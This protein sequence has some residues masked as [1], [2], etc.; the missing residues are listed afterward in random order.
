MAS[1]LLVDDDDAGLELRKLIFEREGHQVLIARDADE[2]R[3]LFFRARPDC[4]VLDIRLPEAAD[5][6]GLIRD[7]RS[8]AAGVRIVVLC[9]WPLDLDATP[10]AGMADVVLAKPVRSAALVGALSGPDRS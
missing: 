2:A 7:F 10:E 4:V 3:A 8:A 9:G 5:G 1:V 6:L